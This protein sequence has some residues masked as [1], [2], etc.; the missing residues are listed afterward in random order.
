MRRARFRQLTIFDLG[1][2]LR[3]S[4]LVPI[5]ELNR[6]ALGLCSTNDSCLV[7][8]ESLTVRLDMQ[9]PAYGIE[10]E[11]G[12]EAGGTGDGRLPGKGTVLSP[13]PPTCACC[14]DTEA[15]GTPP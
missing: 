3:T 15:A 6:M 10:E 14:V 5:S 9:D 13:L 8:C 2:T 7:F 11:T 12:T 4:P 1:M